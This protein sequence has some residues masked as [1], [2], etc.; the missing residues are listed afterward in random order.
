MDKEKEFRERIF[1]DID[2]VSMSVRQI[3]DRDASR[4]YS[5]DEEM[6]VSV[7]F[8]RG[9]IDKLLPDLN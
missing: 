7:M 9:V 2:K 4:F 8:V 1:K 3:K 5:G 6:F